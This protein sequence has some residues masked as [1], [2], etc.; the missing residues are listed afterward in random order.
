MKITGI[1]EVET[2]T[3]VVCDMPLLHRGWILE[4]ISLA[5]YKHTRVIA[6]HDGMH[7]ELHLRNDSFLQA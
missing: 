6:P 7:C 2:V 4:R 3:G 1:V 5:S